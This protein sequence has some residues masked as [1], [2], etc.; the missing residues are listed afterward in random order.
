MTQNEKAAAS[1][2]RKH[3]IMIVLLVIVFILFI[4]PFILVLINV[5]KDQADITSNPLKRWRRWTSSTYS[6]TH[7]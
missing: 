5:F 3:A 7:C 2:K 4:A 1:R 6:R